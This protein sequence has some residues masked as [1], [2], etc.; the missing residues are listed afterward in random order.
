MLIKF[1]APEHTYPALARHL[2]APEPEDV[3]VAAFVTS[4]RGLAIWVSVTTPA[5]AVV[6]AIPTLIFHLAKH[7][8]RDI[9]SAEARMSASIIQD[10]RPLA[11]R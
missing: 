5:V 9:Q 11:L 3:P 2:T 1:F 8:R 10:A 7:A 4:W 6:R